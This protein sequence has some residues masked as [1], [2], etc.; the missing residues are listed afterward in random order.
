[1]EIRDRSA[2][3]P[4]RGRNGKRK[5][6]V[7]VRGTEHAYFESKKHTVPKEAKTYGWKSPT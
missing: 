4:S 7:K 3:K 6:T 5:P 2:K 1:M